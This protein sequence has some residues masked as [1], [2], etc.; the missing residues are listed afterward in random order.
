M[1]ARIVLAPPIV[2]APA[3]GPLAVVRRHPLVTFVA[4]A[5][6]LTWLIEIPWVAGERHWLPFQVPVPLVLLMGWMPGLAAILVTAALGG[7]AG[8]RAL[9]RRLV[10]W[11]VNPA[12]YAAPIAGSAALWFGGLALASRFGGHGVDLPTFSPGLLIG[13]LVFL[14]L[15]FAINSEELAWRGFALPRMQARHSA[16]GASVVLG[17][18]EGLFHLPLFC[19]PGSDQAATGLPLFLLGSIAGAILFT[20]LFNNTRGSVLLAMLFHTF[21][22]MWLSLFPAPAADQVVSQRA[23]TA[24]LVLAALLVLAVFGPARLARKPATGLPVVVDPPASA[25]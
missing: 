22:N 17:V 3:A 15:F 21:A 23:F 2:V 25:D 14:A 5:F 19:K 11:R 1:S 12:W 6:A 16:L 8:V 20:W 9:L 7:R 18:I 10:I 13:A 24:M 4:L